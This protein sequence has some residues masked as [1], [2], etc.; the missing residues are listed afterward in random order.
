[1]SRVIVYIESYDGYINLEADEFHLEEDGFYKVFNN[2]E[3][4][5]MIRP[6]EIKAIWR[7]DKSGEVVKK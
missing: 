7:S 5:A 6:E 1:M 2:T 4:V 3:C